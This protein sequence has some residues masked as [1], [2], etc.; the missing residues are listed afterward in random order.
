MAL[1]TGDDVETVVDNRKRF[2]ESFSL[3]IQNLV[4]LNQTH[5][6]NIQIITSADSGK[7][8]FTQD[9]A[10][11]DSDAAITNKAGVIL[12][13][14]TA[15]CVP[16]ILIDE[17]NG[18]IA[19]IHAGW[20]GTAAKISSKCALEMISRFGSKAENIKARILPS[21][22]SCCYEVG[23]ETASLCGCEGENRLDL[24]K[25]N[26]KHLIEVGLL[27]T[28]IEISDKCTSCNNE[29]YFSYRAENGTIGRFMSFVVIAEK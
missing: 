11:H 27:T 14:M 22:G 20:K 8:A 26:A 24:K 21:I 29:E 18:V 12:S 16:V 5:S 25:I 2:L 17:A 7:G 23:S 13:I 15:D 10:L 3:N 1:H 19:A 9:S 28:N 6:S 4:C